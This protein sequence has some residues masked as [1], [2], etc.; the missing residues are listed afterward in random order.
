MTDASSVDRV[1]LR[2]QA[3][4]V[5]CTLS[6][7]RLEGEELAA[8]EAHSRRSAIYLPLLFSSSSELT[9]LDL[10]SSCATDLDLLALC[11]GLAT[12]TALTSLSLSDNFWVTDR[13]MCLVATSLFQNST[14]THLVAMRCPRL[15]EDCFASF[16]QPLAEC[17]FALVQLEV[18][19][20]GSVLFSDGRVQRWLQ[21]NRLGKAYSQAVRGRGVDPEQNP[22]D[23]SL[24]R[25][26]T[27]EPL[28]AWS[29]ALLF[30]RFSPSVRH[31][32]LAGQPLDASCADV[33][34]QYLR[35]DR[36]QLE[37][38]DLRQCGLIDSA[39]SRI[40][41]ALDTNK[42]L[43]SLVFGSKGNDVDPDVEKYVELMLFLN[44]QP[45]NFKECALRMMEK[46]E[47]LVFVHLDAAGTGRVFDERMTEIVSTAVAAA[48]HLR[49]VV[50][51]YCGLSGK[52]ATLWAKVLCTNSTL[53]LLDLS[54]NDIGE[55]A[56]SLAQSLK[57]NDAL[58]TLKLSSCSVPHQSA[59]DLADALRKNRSLTE[60]D[61]SGNVLISADAATS[62]SS[63]LSVNSCMKTIRLDGTSI[64]Q[65]LA[66]DVAEKLR[67]SSEP[68]SV[69]AALPQLFGNVPS[70]ATIAA[71]GKSGSWWL[72]DS[73]A[74]LLAQALLVNKYVTSI[75]V[76]ANQ[77]GAEGMVAMCRAVLDAKVPVAL[78]D[79]SQNPLGNGIDKFE[80]VLVDLVRDSRTLATVDVS[81]TGFTH[82]GVRRLI[83]LLSSR[84]CSLRSID[85][86]RNMLIDPNLISELQFHV[87]L[88][89]CSD[90][91]RETAYR[92]T[93]SS[94][95]STIRTLDVSN[96][97][98][99]L[100]ERD[101]TASVRS[102]LYIAAHCPSLTTVLLHG[103]D[104]G[105][106]QIDVIASSIESGRVAVANWDLSGNLLDDRCIN[107]LIQAASRSS[108]IKA[109]DVSGSRVGCSAS[110]VKTL[111]S[112]LEFNKQPTAVREA[113]LGSVESGE[114]ALDFSKRLQHHLTDHQVMLLCS[115][116]VRQHS[117]TAVDVSNNHVGNDGLRC[118]VDLAIG[119]P[120][121]V[122]L[123]LKNTLIREPGVSSEAER[124]I[125]HGVS[126]IT[127]LDL[128]YNDLGPAVGKSLLT[129]LKTN[130]TV[131]SI[132]VT[133]CGV[134][135]EAAEEIAE[136]TE[137]NA[138]Q[139]RRC[140]SR[141]EGNDASMTALT[142][143]PHRMSK[144]VL[145][146]LCRSLRANT[147]LTHLD[148]SGHEIPDA[149]GVW[150]AGELI[151][152]KTLRRVNLSENQL[153]DATLDVLIGGLEHSVWPITSICL[154][155]NAA[156]SDS[157]L[158]WLAE[159]SPVLATNSTLTEFAVD[160][161]GHDAVRHYCASFSLNDQLVLKSALNKLGKND[162][163][164]TRLDLQREAVKNNVSCYQLLKVLPWNTQIEFLSLADGEIDDIGVGYLCEALFLNR[165]VTH[166]DLTHN[167]ISDDGAVRIAD[168]LKVNGVLRSLQL[169]GNEGITRAGTSCI[170]TVLRSVNNAISSISFDREHLPQDVTDDV[171]FSMLLNNSHPT[172]KKLYSATDEVYTV[173]D[174]RNPS[175]IGKS[176][177]DGAC[178][179]L[180]QLL[181]RNSTVTA[182][183][184]SS[185][186]ITIESCFSIENMLKVNTSITSL[187]V[188][189]NMMGEGVKF[190]VRSLNVNK[191]LRSLN[192][193]GIAVEA[194]LK[195]KLSIL[196]RSNREPARFK[197]ETLLLVGDDTVPATF[198]VNCPASKEDRELQTLTDARDDNTSID[199]YATRTKA[200]L[201]DE[202]MDLARVI[203]LRDTS[204]KSVN[205]AFNTIRDV[206]FAHLLEALTAM[207]FIREIYM[208][209]NFLTDE[210]VTRLCDCI[211]NLVMLR[212]VDLSHNR[213]TESCA[214]RAQDTARM[215]PQ[216]FSFNLQDQED[217]IAEEALAPLGFY[218]K[219]NSS[220][221][222]E[223]R[224]QLIRAATNDSTLTHIDFT[225]YRADPP[226]RFD[227]TYVSLLCFALV[228]NTSATH[229]TIADCE[230]SD[231]LVDSLL[232]AMR[233][234]ASIVS[235]DLSQNS[236]DDV[237]K[238][239]DV[240]LQRHVG[241]RSLSIHHNMLSVGS[242]RS[243]AGLLRTTEDL[244]ELDVRENAWGRV[245]ATIIQSS[246]QSN[247]GLRHVQLEGKNVPTSVVTAAKYAVEGLGKA[248]LQKRVA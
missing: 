28:A 245:G 93:Q 30:E 197:E 215:F 62:F 160:D 9:R 174:C 162:P 106:A 190:I 238:L 42:S 82:H 212:H 10:S 136:M 192:I 155:N 213:L 34:C 120:T 2:N 232:G 40:A 59:L 90:P 218:C 129:A 118:L 94:S 240:L 21:I 201:D 103:N 75:D 47:S 109:M 244:E 37:S 128:S 18:N 64:P 235:L 19:A 68:P 193:S 114:P 48:P 78:L 71:S 77:I 36:A 45:C 133:L 95:A 206:G 143:H 92:L 83:E 204:L 202:S 38:L 156:V 67:T 180:C 223:A 221:T 182:V 239:C 166:L 117:F 121:L 123:R 183:D 58:F 222:E 26:V 237:S 122:T 6:E 144:R 134:T 81:A 184:L 173:I 170:E 179:L 108:E 205:F 177:D 23:L 147:F 138:C 79:C 178:K 207:R 86:S 57:S 135:K 60:L 216:L 209:H 146:Y 142:R 22:V 227:M 148:L 187:D 150:L 113:L 3:L 119:M 1:D 167:F 198:T 139:S 115:S 233:E 69:R 228:R 194:D 74:L 87:Q 52:S 116:L 171:D 98:C 15:T 210:S 230:L 124:L 154:T 151:R 110:L 243:L 44:S 145:Q 126:S 225:G 229:L 102:V 32:S 63:M 66:L 153:G 185:T 49:S 220:C 241:L 33:I 169:D 127:H 159:A 149:V 131:T 208:S 231:I 203:I 158:L 25:R 7:S 165:S 168:V 54:G 211:P 50:T 137:A 181:E 200:S 56:T 132:D 97:A 27:N 246:L 91:L 189:G 99:G 175:S 65:E 234:N 196:L 96:V 5:R 53:Q 111:Q 130:T 13:G 70:Y 172:L 29:I 41:L 242:A 14:L 73:S 8:A 12:N 214:V 141:I 248:P 61:L 247:R 219:A 226:W 84:R 161:R 217:A 104:M 43:K 125:A 51:T 11:D 46:D 55:A 4:Q 35:S 236:L 105:I 24:G 152:V 191:T 88:N 164:L 72:R 195:L 163:S 100:P 224:D 186:Q 140:I 17:N 80:D 176:F 31:L 16:L 101:V 157:K 188:S 20:S 85:V 39:T 89:V 107:R 76:S 112:R 199:F